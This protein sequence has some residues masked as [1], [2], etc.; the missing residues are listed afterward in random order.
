MR[1]AAARALELRTDADAYH[2]DLVEALLPPRP[3]K[4]GDMKEWPAEEERARRMVGLA[5]ALASDS[6]SSATPRPR[7]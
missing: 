5:E 2:A 4:A 3:E 6:P 1:Y 7:C